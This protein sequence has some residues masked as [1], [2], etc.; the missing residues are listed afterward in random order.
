MKDIILSRPMLTGALKRGYIP[1]VVI[2]D[3]HTHPVFSYFEHMT[4]EHSPTTLKLGI[5]R[6]FT[7]AKKM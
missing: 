3:V 2:R 1:V 4:A 5:V 6:S 7:L